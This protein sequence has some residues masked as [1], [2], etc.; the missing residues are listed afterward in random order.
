MPLTRE[1]RRIS[2]FSSPPREK[3]DRSGKVIF[4][5]CFLLFNGVL[6]NFF[7]QKRGN[8]ESVF[9]PCQPYI[10]AQQDVGDAPAPPPI[11]RDG[12]NSTTVVLSPECAGS[13]VRGAVCPLTLDNV[14]VRVYFSK[15]TLFRMS[16]FQDI[17]GY[18]MADEAACQYSC[19]RDRECS[20]FTYFR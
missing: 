4:A 6:R 13:F 14:L 15:K 19:F 7:R 11:P 17:D 8:I 16:I 10:V 18:S 3:S 9:K 5:I 1:D 12:L 20:H 2:R